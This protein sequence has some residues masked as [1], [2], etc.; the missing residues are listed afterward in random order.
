MM[1]DEGTGLPLRDVIVRPLV[2]MYDAVQALLAPYHPGGSVP[3]PV[4]GC[5]WSAYVP[6]PRLEWSGDG[7]RVTVDGV[8][9]ETVDRRLYE[10]A[11]RHAETT[12]TLPDGIPDG[13]PD[14][15]LMAGVDPATGWPLEHTGVNVRLAP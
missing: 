11:D 9:R 13:I 12:E 3:C 6:M 2:D 7:T 1:T 8:P 15:D 4:E 10:H 5:G 14:P